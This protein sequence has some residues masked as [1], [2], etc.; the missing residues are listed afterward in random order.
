MP[1]NADQN[2]GIDPNSDQCRSIPIN[3]DNSDIDPNS[4]QCRSIPI[5]ADNA[6]VLIGGVLV[7]LPV[8][9]VDVIG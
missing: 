1:I 9:T 3:A 7:I 6:M 8:L 2:S 5:N 4:D